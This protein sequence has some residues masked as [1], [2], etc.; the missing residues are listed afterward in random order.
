M[1][2][3]IN[4]FLSSGDKFMP[5][6]HLKQPGFTYSASGPFTRNKQKFKHLCKQEIQI[7]FTR[8]NWI[9]RLFSIDLAY[10][11]YKDL[12]KRT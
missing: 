7:I 5:E 6:I 1:N 11:K 8:I 2:D 4:K 10:G 3:I 9:K 12:E